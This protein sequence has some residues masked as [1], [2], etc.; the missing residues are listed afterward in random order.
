M[1]LSDRD[2][3]RDDE[4]SWGGPAGRR[5]HW[6]ATT[7]LMAA[8]T[9]VF[10]LQLA[11][12]LY[13]QHNIDTAEHH[14]DAVQVLNVLDNLLPLSTDGLRHGYVWQ[15]LTFQFLHAGFWHLFGNMFCL[16]MFGRVI[17]QGLGRAN[18]LKLYFL[19]GTVGG[20][21]QALLG[22]LMPDRFGGP[23]LGASAGV[24]GLF[25][26]FA[27]LQPDA[28]IFLWFVLPVTARQLFWFS[29]AVAVFFI[30]EP[31]DSHVANGAHLGGLL[32]GAAFV[33]WRLYTKSLR[34]WLP[35]RAV[36]PQHAHLVRTYSFK[37]NFS[38]HPAAPLEEVPPEEFISREVDPILDK[39]SS[40]G[41]QSLT[42]HE[43]KVLDAARRKMEKR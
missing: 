8:I 40:Q 31:M 33:R 14:E 9:G 42:D 17:E 7:V 23:V 30:V 5:W 12:G 39:I 34:A 27:M 21:V 38:P 24:I 20:L 1:A 4:P 37:Q 41:I 3:M 15:L 19:G 35:A 32:A 13:V 16:W 43:R 36:R 10:L 26:A 11:A 22:F 28:K 6:S 29:I 25:A 2:Y 18:F